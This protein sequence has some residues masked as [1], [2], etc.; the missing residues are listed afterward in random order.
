VQNTVFTPNHRYLA[1]DVIQSAPRAGSY[2]D[3]RNLTGPNPTWL[4]D[5]FNSYDCTARI[6]RGR[7]CV[8]CRYEQTLDQRPGNDI[9]AWDDVAVQCAEDGRRLRAGQPG[10]VWHDSPAFRKTIELDGRRLRIRY[11][12]TQP[13]HLVAN[14]FSVDLADLLEGGERQQRAVRRRTATVTSATGLTVT[15]KLGRGCDFTEATERRRG[16]DTRVLT[17]D[18]QIVATGTG[19]FDYSIEL[20]G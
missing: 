16:P 12:D 10:I 9:L 19:G 1:S 4:P 18:I 17:E 6:R 2:F 3:Q 7:A 14:E 5:N 15:V 11:D 20:P 8:E 13:G